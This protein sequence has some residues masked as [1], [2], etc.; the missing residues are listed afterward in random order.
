MTSEVFIIFKSIQYHNVGKHLPASAPPGQKQDFQD[1]S[2][3]GRIPASFLFLNTTFTSSL[4]FLPVHQS[5]H[6]SLPPQ[7][8]IPVS[9]FVEVMNNI[10]AV[11]KAIRKT[12]S[13]YRAPVPGNL[14]WLAVNVAWTQPINLHYCPALPLVLSVYLDKCSWF[15]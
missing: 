6:E 2:S 9:V 10:S 12:V 7:P 5:A 1:T 15:M 8:R 3:T 14:T 4:F 11:P 13:M